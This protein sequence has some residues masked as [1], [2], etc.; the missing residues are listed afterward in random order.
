MSPA[1]QAKAENERIRS[2][3]EGL[4][5][6]R[7]ARKKTAPGEPCIEIPLEKVYTL[8]DR[9]G[10]PRGVIEIKEVINLVDRIM[11]L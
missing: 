9:D 7:D 11:R 2:L 5:A 10:E 6:I 1:K 4:N 3:I 8:T